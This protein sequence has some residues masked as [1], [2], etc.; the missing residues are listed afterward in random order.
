[1]GQQDVFRADVDSSAVGHGL[2]GI[3]HQVVDDLVYLA[4]IRLH[5]PEGI[6]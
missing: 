2:D 1:M 6:G 5:G 4:R 3:Y